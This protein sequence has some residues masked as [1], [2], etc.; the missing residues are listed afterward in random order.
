MALLSDRLIIALKAARY[1]DLATTFQVLMVEMGEIYCE[2]RRKRMHFNGG[3]RAVRNEGSTRSFN[4]KTT[5]YLADAFIR[6]LSSVLLIL[7]A[8]TFRVNRS[9]SGGIL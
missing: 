4:Y 7:F 2:T 9:L 1:L 8:I 3:P 6:F 5:F